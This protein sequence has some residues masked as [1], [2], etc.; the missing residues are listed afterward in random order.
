[1]EATTIKKTTN[2]GRKQQDST[3]SKSPSVTEVTELLDCM[4]SEINTISQIHSPIK[5][6][7][8]RV[9]PKV[10]LDTSKNC[11]IC[12]KIL[13]NTELIDCPICFIKGSNNCNR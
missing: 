6:Q 10:T 7:V 4:S 8:K 13:G 3:K 12:S 11:F 1:M 2:D 9:T 5:L